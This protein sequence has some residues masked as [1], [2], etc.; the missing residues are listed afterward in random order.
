MAPEA[1]RALAGREARPLAVHVGGGIATRDAYHEQRAAHREALERGTAGAPERL[2]LP[3]VTVPAASIVVAEGGPN[4]RPVVKSEGKQE[5]QARRRA[6]ATAAAGGMAGGEVEPPLEGQPPVVGSESE[7][8]DE[9]ASSDDER[10]AR[11]GRT[12]RPRPTLCLALGQQAA[13]EGAAATAGTPPASLLN[14]HGHGLSMALRSLCRRLCEYVAEQADVGGVV[15]MYDAGGGMQY[16]QYIVTT[17]S[18]IAQY[19]VH[20]DVRCSTRSHL[21]KCT[22]QCSVGMQHWTMHFFKWLRAPHV[23]GGRRRLCVGA[24]PVRGLGGTRHALAGRERAS[25]KRG[26]GGEGQGGERERARF[27]AQGDAPPEQVRGGGLGRGP[28]GRGGARGGTI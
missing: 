15:T 18:Y 1:I 4:Y 7:D 25:D 5:K 10:A 27:R 23:R 24:A 22:V 16:A 17:A 20:R 9:S 14:P 13:V 6:K 11:L 8:S 26:R 3:V 28:L 2:A 19:I 12:G 21:K